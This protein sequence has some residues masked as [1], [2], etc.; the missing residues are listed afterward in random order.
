VLVQ[1]YLGAL[2][3][4]LDAGLTY[5]TWPLIDGALM[6]SATRLWFLQ[7]AWRNIF[8]NALTVQFDH[9]MAAY[10]LWIGALLHAVDVA[11]IARGSLLRGALAL[12]VAITLQA[13]IGIVT[14]LYKAALP[15]ALLHQGMAMVV[16][17]IAVLHAEQLMN[18]RVPAL[19]AA[20]GPISPIRPRALARDRQ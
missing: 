20:T 16:L 5:N 12:A 19:G 4:G 13:G 15:F 10:T 3:A 17:T 8:D 6:P 9:R 14:L 18:R 7:P 11:R 1:I 2:V